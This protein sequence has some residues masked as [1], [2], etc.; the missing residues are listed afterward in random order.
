MNDF[1]IILKDGLKGCCSTYS[2]R[3]LNELTK[4]WFESNPDIR[5]NIKDIMEDEW[6]TDEIA[7]Y[8]FQQFGDRIFPLTYLNGKPVMAGF[9]PEKKDLLD[10]L[11]NP[12]YITKEDIRKAKEKT[13]NS[14]VEK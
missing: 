1:E 9:F 7:G 12:Q 10:S 11:Q 8:G 4:V 14:E 2:A 3:E 6:E 5:L 13:V